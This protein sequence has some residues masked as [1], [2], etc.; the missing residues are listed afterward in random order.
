MN[1]YIY[2][3]CIRVNM[4]SFRYHKQIKTRLNGGFDLEGSSNPPVD[5]SHVETISR[6]V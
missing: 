4:Q 1:E 5:V 2:I 3:Y 6:L